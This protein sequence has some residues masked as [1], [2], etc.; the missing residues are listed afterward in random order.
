MVLLS[1]IP[2]SGPPKILNVSIAR[3]VARAAEPEDGDRGW[4]IGIANST[5][6]V[7]FVHTPAQWRAEL[8]M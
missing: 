1:L 5:S 3:A 6:A 8:G 7:N 4:D 2:G